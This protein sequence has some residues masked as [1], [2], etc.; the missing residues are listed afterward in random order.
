MHLRLA[1]IGP[2]GLD[3]GVLGNRKPEPVLSQSALSRAHL[4][5][6]ALSR[7]GPT[8]PNRAGAARSTRKMLP[9]SAAVSARALPGIRCSR[10]CTEE[11][12]S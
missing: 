12:G 7:R 10:L 9:A 1:A 5:Y 11:L 6:A 4:S 8:M 3:A 2:A